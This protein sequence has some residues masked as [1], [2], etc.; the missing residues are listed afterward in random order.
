MEAAIIIQKWWRG[1]KTTVI[2]NFGHIVD[3][4]FSLPIADHTEVKVNIYKQ[5][6]TI[7]SLVKKV[8]HK[9]FSFC[10]KLNDHG[11]LIIEGA[12]RKIRDLPRK[13]RVWKT[14]F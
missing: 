10:Y 7:N 5:D 12:E 9:N 13:N 6:F 2:L 4:I 1:L 3:R 14:S 11:P 8:V